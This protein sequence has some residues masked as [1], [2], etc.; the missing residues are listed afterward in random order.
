M[1]TNAGSVWTRRQRAR[2][3]MAQVKAEEMWRQKGFF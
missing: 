1:L 2:K 3:D